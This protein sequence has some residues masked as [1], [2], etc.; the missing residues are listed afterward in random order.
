MNYL[1]NL[2]DSDNFLYDQVYAITFDCIHKEFY[3]A[4][5]SNDTI[6]R[7]E[8]FILQELK[9]KFPYTRIIINVE[10][11]NMGHISVDMSRAPELNYYDYGY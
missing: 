10:C 6:L 2:S 5:A 7:L 1:P 8:S 11:D 3:G 4:V 9:D